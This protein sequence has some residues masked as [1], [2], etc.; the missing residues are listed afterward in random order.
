MNQGPGHVLLTYINYLYSLK[1][2]YMHRSAV[3]SCWTL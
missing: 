3:C 2:D 1:S